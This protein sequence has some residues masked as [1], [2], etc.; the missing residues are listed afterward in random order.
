MK[1]NRRAVTVSIVIVLLAVGGLQVYSAMTPLVRFGPDGPSGA[2]FDPNS[3]AAEVHGAAAECAVRQKNLFLWIEAYR[4]KHGQVPDCID[5]LINDDHRSS[6]FCNCGLGSSYVLHP[7]NYGN[8]N[9]VFI[10]EE[11]NRHTG[12]LLLWLKGVKPRVQTMGD[13]TIHLYEGGK[14]ITMQAKK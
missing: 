13:G 9:G 5:T 7:E 2:V 10:S 4:E 11:P 6:T 14:P 1:P 8:P 12:C 3:K